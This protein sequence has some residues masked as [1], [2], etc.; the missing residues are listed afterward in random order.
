[1]NKICKTLIKIYLPP[2]HF[3]SSLRFYLFC[4]TAKLSTQ[5][6]P[7]LGLTRVHELARN[8]E[9]MYE[10]ATVCMTL[11]WGFRS[12]CSACPKWLRL[13]NVHALLGSS[14]PSQSAHVGKK[15]LNK[16]YG[17]IQRPRSLQGMHTELCLCGCP[18]LSTTCEPVSVRSVN[19]STMGIFQVGI[20]FKS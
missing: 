1:M 6:W 2:G 11:V 16:T 15:V 8:L 19:I 9:K 3:F 14:T 20:P 10:K 13:N 17:E 4:Y 7:W 12:I 5:Q 18:N